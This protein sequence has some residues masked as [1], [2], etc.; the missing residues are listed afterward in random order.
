MRTNLK[1]F[2]LS[3]VA[4]LVF[5][6]TGCNS[7]E[8]NANHSDTAQLVPGTNDTIPSV[9]NPGVGDT[10]SVITTPPVNDNNTIMPDSTTIAQ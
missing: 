6:V 2:T 5:I 9:V 1:Q 7:G 4:V 3:I 10:S 8:G